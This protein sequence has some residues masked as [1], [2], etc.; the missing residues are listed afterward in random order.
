[1]ALHMV[2]RVAAFS[3]SWAYSA[4]FFRNPGPK[5]GSIFPRPA[6]RPCRAEGRTAR[7]QLA[8]Q[9]VPSVCHG[10]PTSGRRRAPFNPQSSILIP[11]SPRRSAPLPVPGRGDALEQFT[12][13]R[14]VA[15]SWHGHLA[16][17]HGLEGRATRSQPCVNCSREPPGD[18]TLY[19]PSRRG[20]GEPDD[21]APSRIPPDCA[22]P[23]AV[24]G[25]R[26]LTTGHWGFGICSP[27][28]CR[29]GPEAEGGG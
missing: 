15:R 6:A 20:K 2:T 14:V 13:G 5:T 12:V 26:P 27:E 3:R 25:H 22:L 29:E 8:R 19:L 18:L 7:H 10:C 24:T 21:P 1:M 11:Q 4:G 9:S 16:H 28:V 17:V 23:S